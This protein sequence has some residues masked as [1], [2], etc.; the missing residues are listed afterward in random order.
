MATD[1]IIPRSNSLRSVHGRPTLVHRNRSMNAKHVCF[2]RN[3]DRYCP[4]LKL[5][6]SPERYKEFQSLLVELSA[7]MNL[8]SGAVRYIFNSTDGSLVNDISD[9][10]YG[11]AYVCSSSTILR[12]VEGGYGNVTVNNKSSSTPKTPRK[13]LNRHTIHVSNPDNL[14]LYSSGSALNDSK[15]FVKPKL[16]TVIR[17]G[18]P[19]QKKVTLLL[20][21]KTA[22]SY[23]QVLDQ[24]SARGSLG[25]VD[26]LYT[27]DGRCIKELRDLFDDDT[28]F[29]ALS[30][31]E[32][33]PDDGVELDP[34][35]YRLTKYRELNKSRNNSGMRRSNTLRERSN[36]LRSLPDTSDFNRS[37]DQRRKSYG[38]LTDLNRTQ[39]SCPKSKGNSKPKVTVHKKVIR[40]NKNMR[41]QDSKK[42]SS[43]DELYPTS[44]FQ[45]ES[46]D[47]EV[48]LNCSLESATSRILI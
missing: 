4:G 38:R 41:R 29:I 2:Y 13:N 46:S 34:S 3:G 8:A 11:I 43:G 1:Q 42:E 12:Q 45:P 30:S 33:F 23:E 7:K 44:V 36:S 31:S 15:D 16:V 6:I 25:K 17:N 27:V 18:K 28:I 24:L 26:K 9:L 37:M 40:P 39:D 5:A 22:V 21:N 35:S 48:D 14:S 47:S 10:Q 20:N 32:K 19:P